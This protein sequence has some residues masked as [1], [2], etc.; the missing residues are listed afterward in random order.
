VRGKRMVNR[1]RHT[2]SGLCIRIVRCVSI[3][4]LAGASCT[5]EPSEATAFFL[6]PDEETLQ[7][8]A[9][10]AE[11][12]SSL[13]P[14]DC[15]LADET[16]LALYVDQM[17]SAGF[18]TTEQSIPVTIMRSFSTPGVLTTEITIRVPDHP[19][20]TIELGDHVSPHAN[21][22]SRSIPISDLGLSTEEFS[23]SGMLQ[24]RA[25]FYSPEGL[26]DES[27]SEYLYFH[28][29]EGGWAIYSD[30]V[31][32]REYFG[33]ALTSEER[34]KRELAFASRP[35]DMP[36]AQFAAARV[37]RISEHPNHVPSQ[38]ADQVIE[39]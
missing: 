3:A 31:R 8:D 11:E 34:Q 37:S 21:L 6:G 5:P 22:T 9:S 26:A 10:S 13:L 38:G 32:Q 15:M 19:D 29:V 36:D 25:R 1:S 33:G 20:T 14:G 2:V 7:R 18:L 16:T 35:L 12:A 24:F 39:P 4:S 17:Q 28:P 30:E 27:D 23:V